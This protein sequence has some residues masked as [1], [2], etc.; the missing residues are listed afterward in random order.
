MD[1]ARGPPTEPPLNVRNYDNRYFDGRTHGDVRRMT[2]PEIVYVPDWHHE[3]PYGLTVVG[4][5]ADRLDEAEALA[6]AALAGLVPPASWERTEPELRRRV[7]RACRSI[8]TEGLWHVS[9]DRPEVSEDR[10]RR[11]CLAQ[12][13]DEWPH[14]HLLHEGRAAG[15]RLTALARFSALVCR[16]PPGVL[17]DTAEDLLDL[18]SLRLPA[19]GRPTP[20]TRRVSASTTTSSLPLRTRPRPRP[21]AE[22]T[23]PQATPRPGPGRRAAVRLAPS[24]RRYGVC[25]IGPGPRVTGPQYGRGRP[26]PRSAARA[27]PGPRCP[28]V[29]VFGVALAVFDEVGPAL[30]LSPAR[31]RARPAGSRAPS[32][33][34]VPIRRVPSP[35]ATATTT[36]CAR[37]RTHV[38]HLAP[39][40]G[41]SAPPPGQWS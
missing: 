18:Q 35:V 12:L 9:D 13:R 31:P 28:L 14:A 5:A 20:T 33:A 6:S 22:E 26:H 25:G 37:S 27:R 10:S 36:G 32:R 3:P 8:P 15:P 11:D 39:P 21:E 34:A 4:V 30:A 38:T 19:S 24:L 17:L 16:M 2:R 23:T 29:L 41:V 1:P 7:V 40:P